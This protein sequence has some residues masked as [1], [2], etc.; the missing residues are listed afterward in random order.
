MSKLGKYI[1]DFV[2]GLI[3]KVIGWFFCISFLL[4]AY[5]V[6]YGLAVRY[7]GGLNPDDRNLEYKYDR[8]SDRLAERRL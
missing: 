6:G 7:L 1:G 8:L 2:S 3:V 5:F 4:T